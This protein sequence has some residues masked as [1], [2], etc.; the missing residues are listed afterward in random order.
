MHDGSPSLGCVGSIFR[1]S[2]SPS[3]CVSVSC[4]PN[5]NGR[6]GAG[7]RPKQQLASSA[8]HRGC[9]SSGSKC[10]R[11]AVR[12]EGLFAKRILPTAASCQPHARLRGSMGSVSRLRRGPHAAE[13][14]TPRGRSATEFKRDQLRG[15]SP[16]LHSGKQR[17]RTAQTDGDHRHHSASLLQLRGQRRAHKLSRCAA[18]SSQAAKE[19]RTGGAAVAGSEARGTDRGANRREDAFSYIRIIR[20]GLQGPQ[21]FQ[22]PN[23]HDVLA[24]GD[25]PPSTGSKNDGGRILARSS[26][27]ARCSIVW[28]GVSWCGAA[29]C[30]AGGCGASV[31]A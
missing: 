15:L 26:N 14:E 30:S 17:L 27:A 12:V 16:P 22:V 5:L 28:S 21:C 9:C 18:A 2:F 10:G 20:L 31:F 11:V 19:R 24:A 3:A 23:Q 4:S 7:A 29:G 8:S 1:P 13:Q 6:A 25:K